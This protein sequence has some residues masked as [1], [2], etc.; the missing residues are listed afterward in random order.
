MGGLARERIA[1]F[2]N[3]VGLT[4]PPEPDHL[5]ALLGLYASLTERASRH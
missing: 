1:G 4:P 3:A 5:A 2:W